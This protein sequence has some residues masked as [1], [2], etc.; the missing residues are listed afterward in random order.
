M[1]TINPG[2]RPATKEMIDTVDNHNASVGALKRFN[3]NATFYSPEGTPFTI[4][5]DITAVL[6]R[7]KIHTGCSIGDCSMI[8]AD[9][10]IHAGAQLGSC[11]FVNRGAVVGMKTILYDA[12]LIGQDVTVGN[13]CIIGPRCTVVDDVPDNT[14]V[15][16]DV[17]FGIDSHPEDTAQNDA[18]GVAI[19]MRRMQH[20]DGGSQLKRQA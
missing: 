19:L 10:V 15:M 12:C 2:A 9:A 8:D 5:C 18:S 17:T 13:N 11:V 14:I 6:D 20:D 16:P 3:P 7:C 1:T 4:E